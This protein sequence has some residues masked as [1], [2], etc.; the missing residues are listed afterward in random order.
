MQTRAFWNPGW[1]ALPLAIACGNNDNVVSDGPGGES[2]VGGAAGAAAAGAAGASSGGSGVGG[3]A[4]SGGAANGGASAGGPASGGAAGVSSA[5]AGGAAP[6][7]T[8]DDPES[9][10]NG[11]TCADLCD[12]WFAR[13]L[14]I[15]DAL[16]DVYPDV[17]ACVTSCTEVSDATMCC[18]AGFLTA[19]IDS[20]THRWAGCGVFSGLVDPPEC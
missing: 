1:L 5:G 17:A 6:L 15:D 20:D 8:C 2:G 4:A 3:G 19:L 14:G 11:T 7:A 18:P 12:T 9:P 10:L 16:D 13:C